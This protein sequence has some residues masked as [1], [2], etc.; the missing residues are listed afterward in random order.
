MKHSLS[1]IVGVAILTI[2]AVLTIAGTALA[3]RNPLERSVVSKTADG[4]QAPPYPISTPGYI[5]GSDQY[6]RDILSRIMAGTQPT[7]LT[8]IVVATFRLIIGTLF[9]LLRQFSPASVALIVGVFIRA[10]TYLPQLFGALLVLVLAGTSPQL[11]VFIV[12]LVWSGWGDVAQI[13]SQRTAKFRQQLVYDAAVSSGAT[14]QSILVR[15]VRRHLAP[16][17]GMLWLREMSNSLALLA[18]LGFLGYFVGGAQ[19]IIV[20]G[21]AV[22]IGARTSDIPELGQLLATSFERVLEPQAMFMV[23]G[24]IALILLGFNLLGDGLRTR[25]SYLPRATRVGLWKQVVFASEWWASRL[26][27]WQIILFCVVIS[28]GAIVPFVSFSGRSASMTSTK[29]T[30]H[31]WQLNTTWRDARA[32]A[33]GSFRGPPLAVPRT[34]DTLPAPP[35]E[36]ASVVISNRAGDLVG[37]STTPGLLIFEQRTERWSEYPLK[38]KPVGNPSLTHDE[39]IV[40]VGAQG[41]IA[42]YDFDGIQRSS[43]TV[44]TRAIA[45]AGATVDNDGNVY[46]TVV[47]RVESFDHTG[48]WRWVTPKV[49]LF[50]EHQAQLSPDGDL[51]ILGSEVFDAADGA[52]LPL[53]AAPTSTE[54]ENPLIISGADGYLY[55][56]I[57]HRLR[58]LDVQNFTPTTIAELGWNANQVTMFFP[59]RSG[60]TAHGIGWMVYK[61]FGGIGR[62]VW[63]IPNQEAIQIPIDTSMNVMFVAD[64]GQFFACNMR[65]CITH[66]IGNPNPNWRMQLPAGTSK[67]IGASVGTTQDIL[68]TTP[69]HALRI[70]P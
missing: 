12:A 53:F 70:T 10:I 17:W 63:L 3:P 14:Q 32:D 27:R 34:V 69:E 22:P 38:F 56:R 29:T 46:V 47:D 5:L 49:M 19:W 55:Q 40:V 2:V 31:I 45:T 59:E 67:V 60:V 50:G 23:G 65:E 41:F 68:I 39:E 13:I 20:A 42:E 1:F 11:G 54:F 15:H 48:E 6:G 30:D 51:V 61:G 21:D 25:M 52:R 24:Y 62:F 57:S 37:Y 36:L 35:H 4:Y 44:K 8:I 9:G 16:L 18:M 43:Y 66:S 64:E 7:M 28:A 26:P 33:G 58:Q